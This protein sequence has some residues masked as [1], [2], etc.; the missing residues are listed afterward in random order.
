MNGGK[1]GGSGKGVR[2]LVWILMLLVMGGVLF[3]RSR[4]DSSLSSG[5]TFGAVVV[6]AIL[7]IVQKKLDEKYA[8]ADLAEMEREAAELEDEFD[9]LDEDDGT[10]GSHYLDLEDEHPAFLVVMG[11]PSDTIYQLIRGERQYHFVKL[12]W[13]EMNVS[14]AEKLIDPRGS[15]AE[16]AARMKKGY[17]ISKADIQ[18]VS[19]KFCRC[20]ST[21]Q[22]NLG[23]LKLDTT[24]G[25]KSFIL[26]D[27]QELM[28]EDVQDFFSDLR[29]VTEVDTRALERE[30]Q[31]GAAVQEELEQIRVGHDPEKARRLKPLGTILIILAVIIEGAWVFLD[32]PYLL[33]SILSV[34]LFLAPFVLVLVKPAYFT[35]LDLGSRKKAEKYK[36]NGIVTV[37]VFAP[38]LIAAMG[39]ALRSLVD[40]NIL[41][42]SALLIAMGVFSLAL[43]LV[44][45]FGYRDI[46]GKPGQAVLLFVLLMMFS[47]GFVVQMNYLLDFGEPDVAYT[48][49]LDKRI[50]TS[51][52]SPDSYLLTVS[53]DEQKQELQAPPD[54]YDVTE[55]GDDVIITTYSGAFG[56]RYAD[57]W[58]VDEWEAYQTEIN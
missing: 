22:P 13:G 44:M 52:K 27:V 35:M 4:V 46:K 24:D 31:E 38:V 49:V 32:V 56:I 21:Q 15:D 10:D 39:L 48:E 1:K 30:A 17:S 33:F 47:C 54:L 20:V 41:N 58:S 14:W 45:Y 26:L 28:P 6:L 11:F 40:F 53:V 34:V 2:A 50:S 18:H 3:L 9:E 7:L 55:I 51:S 37:D 36:E 43:T 12:G 19:L 5:M 16:I 25:K 29:S 8:D 42:W 23:S 57:V